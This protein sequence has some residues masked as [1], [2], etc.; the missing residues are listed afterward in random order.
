VGLV[1]APLPAPEA[2]LL[3]VL[4]IELWKFIRLWRSERASRVKKSE[5][6]LL[7]RQAL[8][9]L[10]GGEKPYWQFTLECYRGNVIQAV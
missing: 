4:A 3:S 1:S 6:A 10:L 7:R 2:G 9:G 5:R 8:I